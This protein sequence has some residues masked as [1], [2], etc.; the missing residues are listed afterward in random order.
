MKQWLDLKAEERALKERREEVESQ[1]YIALKSE[2]KEDSQATWNFD[3]YKL[4]IK[5]NY[6]VK[7]DQE[8]A[9]LRP[10]LFKV[11]YEMTY[12][13]FRKTNEADDF[14]TITPIKPTFI[15]EK[16]EE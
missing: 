12:S 16:K 9:A 2:I 10:D 13:Q 15:V 5:P 3:E 7:V 4:V 11:K 8:K 14:V 1:L 6:S